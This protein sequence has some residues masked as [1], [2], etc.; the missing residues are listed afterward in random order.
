MHNYP[1]LLLMIVF[2]DRTY[3]FN[4]FWKILINIRNKPMTLSNKYIYR[5][6]ITILFLV[7][8]TR[9]KDNL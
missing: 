3:F 2:Q 5:F 8:I 4:L 9:K 1:L 7:T 6:D